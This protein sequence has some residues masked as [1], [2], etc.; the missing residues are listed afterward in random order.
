[1]P[2]IYRNQYCNKESAK[3][4]AGIEII[5]ASDG[6]NMF[7]DGKISSPWATNAPAV[8]MDFS[9]IV[10]PAAPP[11]RMPAVEKVVRR[12][13]NPP[14]YAF[15][16]GVLSMQWVVGTLG[17]KSFDFRASDERCVLSA[18]S[19]VRIRGAKLGMPA[20]YLEWICGDD[21]EVTVTE[22]GMFLT[23]K[24]FEELERE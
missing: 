10:V 18:A 8:D 20:L 1:M 15:I 9:Q 21:P 3:V 24:F 16:H 2:S 14:P 19:E 6:Q 23:R 5:G 4:N 7:E 12:L 11:K 17:M 22:Q 13:L